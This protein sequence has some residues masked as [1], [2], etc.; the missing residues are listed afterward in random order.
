[1]TWSDFCAE[2]AKRIG[3][4]I[5]GKTLYRWCIWRS[6]GTLDYPAQDIPESVLYR[7]A[8]EITVEKWSH[9]T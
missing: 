3:W 9:G 8:R 7:A 4:D 1:M 5:D 2:Q 6:P